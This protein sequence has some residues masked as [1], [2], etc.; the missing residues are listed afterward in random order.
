MNPKTAL[1]CTAL[2]AGLAGV[3]W[4]NRQD[5]PPPVSAAAPLRVPTALTSGSSINPF[6]NAQWRLATSLPSAAPS[7]LI[8]DAVPAFG[9]GERPHFE[10]DR[11]GSLVVNAETRH[12]LERLLALNDPQAALTLLQQVAETL[13]TAAAREATDAF[14][15]Y[16]RYAQALQQAFSPYH[17]ATDEVA[18]VQQLKL[19]H[20]LRAAQFGATTA[21]AYFGEEQA[22]ARRLLDDIQARSTVGST[23]M[24]RAE[25]TQQ[26]AALPA[27]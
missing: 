20:A 27:P 24:E 19:L 11:H 14:H 10:V 9:S 3:L 8:D 1:V 21:Q 26:S 15:A 5:D 25:Q 4:T 12:A 6:T 7:R 13:P 17:P 23:L 18:A 16:R 2:V 22:S